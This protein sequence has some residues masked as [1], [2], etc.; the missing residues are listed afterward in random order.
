MAYDVYGRQ[1]F[2]YLPYTASS[3][4]GGYRT[5]ALTAG[6]GVSL[7]YNPSGSGT[8]QSNGVVRTATPMAETGFEASP[9]NRVTEQGAPGDDWQLAAG[10][11]QR[12][13]YA[14]NNQTAFSGTP[15]TNN[16]GCRKVA[17]YSATINSDFSRTLVRASTN[18]GFYTSGQLYVTIS[19]NENW[20]PAAD[21]CLNTVE[22]YKD[23]DGQV[24]LKRSYRLNG[25]AVEML[26]TYYVYDDR[27]N[28]SLC[29]RHWPTPITAVYPPPLYL[30]AC[31]TSTS[32][33][34]AT[35]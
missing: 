13:V 3:A 22:E 32:T 4:S 34:C 33:T 7:F 30:T 6:A 23:K 21:G 26:S 14:T 16:A 17:L 29:C 12:L 8:P 28:L 15:V 31:A 24:V 5:D 1:V 10:H 35:A 9:L 20:D 2:K 27:G 11:T 18:S 19:R 25:S